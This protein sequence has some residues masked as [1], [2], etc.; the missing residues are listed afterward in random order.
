MSRT[1]RTFRLSVKSLL[2]HP[3]RSALTVLGIFI[4]VC[5]VIWLLAIGEGIGRAA[6]DQIADLGARNIIVRTVKPNNDEATDSGY[7]LTRADYERLRDTIPTIE[8]GGA[9]P[10][11]IITEEFRNRT[12]AKE[13][14]LVGCTPQYADVTRL[15]VAE[16]RF[17]TA[18]DAAEER[19]YC[20]LSAEN[21]QEL[22]PLGTPIG[23]ELMIGEDFYTVVGVMKPRAASAG[24]GGSYAAEDFSGDVYIPIETFWRRIG[25]MIII[26]KPGSFQRDI[27]EVTQVTLQVADRDMVL[28]TR[29][30]VINTIAPYHTLEDFRVTAPLE[31]LQQAQTTRL[32][33]ML[34]LGLIAAVSLVVG[35]IGIMNIMLATVTERTREIGIRRALGAK[36]RDITQQFLSEAVVLSVVG[37]LLGVLGGLMCRPI[38]ALA[39]N[40]LEAWF[41]EQMST[42]PELVRNVEPLLVPWSFPLAFAISAVVG[43][44]FGVYP[45]IR[46]A[47]LDPIEALRHE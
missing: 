26:T 10:I 30:L 46:A 25:D 17:L 38:T 36:R 34:F 43:V 13:G 15:Q 7:G 18:A 39:R 45:A 8:P 33:F 42:L 14:R 44:L 28:P 12:R 47:R 2:L 11:R 27:S 29:D 32:M 20:V 1:W 24:I 6:E 37:G 21:A 16:G 9:L 4:G 41:P 40:R 19:N 35:G 5:G 22:F 3:L 31:L 23:Q